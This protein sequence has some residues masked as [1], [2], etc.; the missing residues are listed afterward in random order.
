MSYT[1]PEWRTAVS[2]VLLL[3]VQQ[4]PELDWAAI[5]LTPIIEA[6]AG[7]PNRPLTTAS[8]EA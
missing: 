1:L 7:K 4:H 3:L 5:N 6:A 2:Q 8:K